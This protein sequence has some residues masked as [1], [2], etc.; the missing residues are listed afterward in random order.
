[1][2]RRIPHDGVAK[3][4][5]EDISVCEKGL[6]VMIDERKAALKI[7]R[8]VPLSEVADLSILREAQREIGIK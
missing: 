8:D 7:T 2:Q 1:M 6:R 4:Y 5:N 3:I